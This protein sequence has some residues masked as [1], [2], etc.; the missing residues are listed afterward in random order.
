MMIYC[1]NSSIIKTPIIKKKKTKS[2]IRIVSDEI[3]Y[4][5]RLL[6]EICSLIEMYIS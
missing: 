4:V 3:L 2:S 1:I 6:L 5:F